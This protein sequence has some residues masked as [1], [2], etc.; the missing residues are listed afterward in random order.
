MCWPGWPWLWHEYT[1]HFIYTAI[2]VWYRSLSLL[3]GINEHIYF[4]QNMSKSVQ[5]RDK[6]M[7]KCW[8]QTEFLLFHIYQEFLIHSFPLLQ[9]IIFLHSNSIT[10]VGVN[11]FCPTVPK[12]KK[13]LYS[14]ISLSNNPVK[15]WEVQPATFRCVLS[16]MSVQLGNFRK[17]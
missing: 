8:L 1:P 7:N 15:Y 2:S 11:D 5:N 14:A 17:W 16:R 6:A 4:K 9:Q 12:M 3:T 13:S 10:K